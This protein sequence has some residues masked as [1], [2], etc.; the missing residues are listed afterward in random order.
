MDS[1][2]YVY[3]GQPDLKVSGNIVIH[4]LAN[5]PQNKWHRLFFDNWYTGLDL[6][7]TL[8]DQVI[9]CVGIVRTNRLP[10][11]K[12]PT[13]TAL[14]GQG[15][16]GL[17]YYFHRQSWALRN[18]MVWQQRGHNFDKLW[19]SKSWWGCWLLGPKNE[20]YGSSAKIIYCY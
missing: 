2:I 6:V 17:L 14:K 12:L 1:S 18:K 20:N 5:V 3:P 15:R 7:K 10:N 16:G 13:D 11:V 8:Y 4:L 9:A 19:G